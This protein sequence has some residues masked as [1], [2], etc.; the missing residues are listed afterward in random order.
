M[1]ASAEAG[2]VVPERV[3]PPGFVSKALRFA[4][5]HPYM[6]GLI[7]AFAVAGAAF[8]AA[9]DADGRALPSAKGSWWGCGWVLLRALP[10]W[11][12]ALRV[13]CRDEETRRLRVSAARSRLRRPHRTAAELL[14]QIRSGSPPAVV[15]VRSRGEFE[16]S[17]VPGAVHIPFYSLL[18]SEEDI[19]AAAGDDETVVVYCEHGPRAGIARAQLWFVTDR[20]IRF[21]EGHMTAWKEDGLPVET[22]A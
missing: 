11:L 6:V 18:G 15:D 21:L 12:P 22:A 4:R 9:L 8:G 5:E 17:H 20:P 7:L 1:S 16:T 10:A 19:P 14:S 2:I 3:E 13:D